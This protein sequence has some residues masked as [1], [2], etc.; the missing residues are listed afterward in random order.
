MPGMLL[1]LIAYAGKVLALD[2]GD[3]AALVQAKMTAELGNNSIHGN[4][5]LRRDQATPVAQC[6][7]AVPTAHPLF[8]YKTE[9]RLCAGTYCV[10]ECGD[11]VYNAAF[12]CPGAESPLCTKPNHTNGTGHDGC[13]LGGELKALFLDFDGTIE[14]NDELAEHVNEQLEKDWDARNGNGSFA[15]LK[16]TDPTGAEGS[17]TG[18]DMIKALATVKAD[19]TASGKDFTTTYFDQ[20]EGRLNL[21]K[22]ALE[23]TK[24]NNVRNIVMS[25]SWA[26]ISAEAWK[27]YLANVIDSLALSNHFESI[28]TV[29]DPG[30]KTPGNKGRKMAE[31]M[32][33]SLAGAVHVDNSFKYLQQVICGERMQGVTGSGGGLS[34]KGVTCKDIKTITDAATN[35]GDLECV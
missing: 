26:P 6:E 11:D 33:G 2:A 8:P 9:Q 13:N 7:D 15:Q 34:P 17:V 31:M 30:G 4:I 27:Q 3:D 21:L 12:R 24:T 16:L 35:L 18:E 29:A 25:A 10:A 32:N 14:L 23:F 20:P 1:L 28:E 19:L 5:S 22:T